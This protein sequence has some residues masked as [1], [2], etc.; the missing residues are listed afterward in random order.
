MDKKVIKIVIII[1]LLVS[2]IIPNS[3]KSKG[4]NS[5][6]STKGRDWNIFSLFGLGSGKVQNKKQK[7][8]FFSGFSSF[9]NEINNY[10]LKLSIV[11]FIINLFQQMY[12]GH[13]Q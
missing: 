2:L 8:S 5:N 12:K 11:V 4:D 7:S 10:I 9:M 1:V 3:A 6:G 13:Q